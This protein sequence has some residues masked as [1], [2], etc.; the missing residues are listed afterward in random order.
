MLW[1]L[2]SGICCCCFG[3]TALPTALVSAYGLLLGR[4][5]SSGGRLCSC[6]PAHLLSLL[7]RAGLP[8]AF[9][10]ANGLVVGKRFSLTAGR[11]HPLECC[12]LLVPS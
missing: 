8:T 2:Q 10:S 4:V 6:S 11:L 12:R 1:G 3:L 9:L 5:L 7:G